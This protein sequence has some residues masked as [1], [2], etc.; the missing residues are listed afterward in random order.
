VREDIQKRVGKE[1]DTD[2]R[3][4]AYGGK[5]KNGKGFDIR[6]DSR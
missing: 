1:V 3:K 5:G 2:T 6:H 4:N